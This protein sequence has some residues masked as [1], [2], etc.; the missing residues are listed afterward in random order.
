V[1]DWPADTA[2][3]DRLLAFAADHPVGQGL[4]SHIEVTRSPGVDYAIRT[5]YQPEEPP[6]QL[7]MADL[8]ALRRAV[9]EA[10]DAPGI[11]PY[12][13]F[14]VYHGVPDRHFG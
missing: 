13:K 5:T 6:L 1:F 14:V 4:G 9:E 7:A 2:T 10:G 3:V 12:E 8:R 11:H